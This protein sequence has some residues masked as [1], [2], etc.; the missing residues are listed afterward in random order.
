MT[1]SRPETVQSY[2]TNVYNILCTIGLIVQKMNKPSGKKNNCTRQSA[3]HFAQKI[4][5]KP[6][7]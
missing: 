3:S 6:V 1:P 4:Y 5:D 7:E 2:S